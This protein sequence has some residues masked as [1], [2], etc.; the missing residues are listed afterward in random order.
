MLDLFWVYSLFRD[1]GEQ[2]SLALR[3][4]FWLQFVNVSAV[5]LLLIFTASLAAVIGNVFP[6]ATAFLLVTEII[7]FAIMITIDGVAIRAAEAE[8]QQE[9]KRMK[10]RQRES[11]VVPPPKAD[12]RFSLG[13]KKRW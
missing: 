10:Q 1:F 5:L 12:A 7:S 2:V 3:W 11:I 9:S 4:K 8:G 6:V 13:R